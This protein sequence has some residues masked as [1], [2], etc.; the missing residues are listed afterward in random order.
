MRD[1]R[2]FLALLAA[3]AV[4]LAL[5][6]ILIDLHMWRGSPSLDMRVDEACFGK[7]GFHMSVSDHGSSGTVFHGF[8]Y[9]IEEEHLY[10]TVRKGLVYGDHRSGSMDV[11]IEDN[12]L[13]LVQSVYLRD[14]P[15]KKLICAR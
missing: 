7:N 2:R 14:G 5:P 1:T 4:L 8:S 13:E 15:E 11:D 9:D 6:G 3:V 10:I 12:R